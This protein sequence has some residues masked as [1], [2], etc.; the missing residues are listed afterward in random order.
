MK[1]LFAHR[2]VSALAPENTLSAIKLCHTHGIKWFEFDVAVLKD[3]TLISHHDDTLDR[4]TD[5]SGALSHT[6]YSQLSKVDAGAWFG[7][8]FVG[9]RIPTLLEVIHCMNDLK[10]NANIEI[11]AGI[12]S[13]T[14]SEAFLASI[15]EQIKGIEPTIAVI[16]SSFNHILLKRFKELNPHI[17]VGCL[18]TKENL[19]EDWKSIVQWCKADYIHPE[20]SG[21]TKSM[22]QDFLATGLK[23]NV[24]TVNTLDRA[25]ELFNWGVNGVFTD[26]PHLFP[27]AYKS[28]TNRY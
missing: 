14:E 27:S 21:L 13:E 12:L 20:S 8:S 9:E 16:V 6:T 3:G 26:I 17:P 24:W 7:D 4:C 18:F 1:T 5:T 22:V 10:L 15:T 25:N 23:V 2:G 19:W 28:T 11:K